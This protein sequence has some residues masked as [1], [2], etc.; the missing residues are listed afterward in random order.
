MAKALYMDDAYLK[1][2]EATITSVKDGR[3]IVLDKTAFYP[4]GGGQPHDTGTL[5]R[6]GET[7]RVVFT[8]KF[9]GDIS[10]EVDKAGL[11]QGDKVQGIIDW[12]RRYALMRYH[13][14]A[15]I[16]SGVFNKEAGALITGNQLDIAKGRIDFSLEEFDREKMAAYFEMAQAIAEKDLPIKVY[17]MDREE[18]LHIPEMVKLAGVLPPAV[19][20]L[21][22]VDIEGF[23]RQADGGT[24]VRSTREIGK[25]VFTKAENKGKNNRRV[26]YTLRTA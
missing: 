7:F 13:T 8:G 4:N 1:E 26:Y 3:Y 18:A 17:Y 19:K 22:I 10:H 12:D 21:R 6:D 20:Q 15:H 16:L 14:A 23:D 25:I 2:F 9:S 5:L 24:H 11:K